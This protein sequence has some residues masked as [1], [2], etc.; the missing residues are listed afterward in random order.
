MGSV[1]NIVRRGPVNG[2]VMLLEPS[3]LEGHSSCAAG[4]K[5]DFAE[6]LGQSDKRGRWL[7]PRLGLAGTAGGARGEPHNKKVQPS[8]RSGVW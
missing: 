1:F 6:G 5:V 2:V 7:G 4:L 3:S 8:L